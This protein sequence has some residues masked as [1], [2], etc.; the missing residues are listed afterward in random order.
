MT[1]PIMAWFGPPNN[2]AV[3]KSPADGMNVSTVAAKTPGSDSGSV[4][5]RNARVGLAFERT[6]GV[7][8]ERPGGF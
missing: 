8:D 5:R 1:F 6:Q 7:D 2:S 3:M 4:T